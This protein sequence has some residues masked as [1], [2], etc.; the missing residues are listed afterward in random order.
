MNENDIIGNRPKILPP[1]ADVVF[2]V[3]IPNS[4]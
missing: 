2:K 4:E 1:K 3:I